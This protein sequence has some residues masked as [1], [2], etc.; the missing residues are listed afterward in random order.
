MSQLSGHG[1]RCNSPVVRHRPVEVDHR[2]VMGAASLVEAGVDR[3][4]LD[5]A[6]VISGE[7]AAEE[8]LVA[9]EAHAATRATGAAAARRAR[10]R[11]GAALGLGRG[12]AADA[13]EGGGVAGVD[14][15]GVGWNNCQLEVKVNWRYCSP[16]QISTKELGTGSQV[17]MSRIPMSMTRGIPL[18]DN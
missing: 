12:R 14:T 6:V 4:E 18:A 10:G 7:A 8:G 1:A 3:R 11:G 17:L 15:G 2:V 16:A 13:A 5:D 9:L